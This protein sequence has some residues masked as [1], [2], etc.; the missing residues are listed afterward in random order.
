MKKQMDMINGSLGDKIIKYAIPLAVTGILQQLFNAADIAVVGRFSGKEAM[1][2][3]G[4]NAPVIGLFIN[5]FVGISLGSNVIIARAIGQKDNTKVSKAVHTSVIVALLGG[6]FLA[7]LGEFLAPS[8]V[9]MLDVP[10]EV[11]PLSIKYLRIYLLGMPVILLYNFESAIYRS[12]GNTRT[13]LIALIISG[14]LNVALNLFF[15]LV[16]GMDVDGVATATVLSNLISSLI[17]LISLIKTDL[18]IKISIKKLRIHKAVFGQILKIGIP[19]GVQGMVFSFAN[20]I[21]QS[22]VNSLGTTIMAASSAAFNLEV[23]VYYIMNSF[24]QACT[25][26]VGQN[27]GAG[28]NDRC[29]KTLRLSLLQSLISTVAV[30]GFVLLFSHPLLSIFNTDIDVISAGQIRLK[31][32]LFAYLFSILQEGLSGYLRGFGVS[33]IPAAC[34]V[35]GICGVRLVWVFTIFQQSPSF[36]RIMQVYP[37]SLGVTAIVI[38]VVMLIVKPSKRYIIKQKA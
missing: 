21:I 23:F 27:Y 26:F 32:I 6:L 18:P 33:F 28:K 25:T 36:A 31:Y 22:A 34:S 12:C 4:S 35:V 17:L 30:G 3:V 38:L 20:I 11:Y 37:L 29:R 19:A 14:V 8:I 16:L 9:N 15:V 1:A 5:L 7:V 13:P 24:G 2:A 10:I